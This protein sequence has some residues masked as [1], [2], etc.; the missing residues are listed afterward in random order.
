MINKIGK[1]KINEEMKE[2]KVF[3][4]VIGDGKNDQ[5]RE[6]YIEK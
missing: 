3:V 5:M 1:R 6:L 2:A 4:I